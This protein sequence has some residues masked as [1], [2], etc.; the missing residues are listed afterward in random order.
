M[1]M[2]CSYISTLLVIPCQ[3]V[4]CGRDTVVLLL[5]SLINFNSFVFAIILGESQRLA[6]L[7]PIDVLSVSLAFWRTNDESTF[8]ACFLVAFL[9]FCQ[10]CLL[11]SQHMNKDCAVLA[12][13]ISL[14]QAG[15]CAL[16]CI[17]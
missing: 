9:I 2:Y 7:P 1:N 17:Y 5:V 12:N 8:G 6:S 3:C 13:F 4:A 10:S 16:Q 15:V 11:F 14:N